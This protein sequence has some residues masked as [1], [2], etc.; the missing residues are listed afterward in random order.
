[1]ELNERQLKKV[2]QENEGENERNQTQ[3]SAFKK[4][5]LENKK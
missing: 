5:I 2:I 3:L 1:M 4:Q